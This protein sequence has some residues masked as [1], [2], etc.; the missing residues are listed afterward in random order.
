MRKKFT[1][2]IEEDSIAWLKQ[3]ALKQEIATGSKV[4][5]ADIINELIEK[6]KTM[7]KFEIIENTVEIKDIRDYY[8]G[9][10]YEQTG[11]QDPSIEATYSTKKEAL[12]AL[13]SYK[14]GAR[15]LSGYWL[16]TEYYVAES[17]YQDDEW[18][19]GGDVWEYAPFDW[20]GLYTDRDLDSM[21]TGGEARAIPGRGCDYIIIKDGKDKEVAYAEELVP[22]D[23]D[24][25]KIYDT[26]DERNGKLIEEI[27]RQFETLLK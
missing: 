12:E 26:Q 4:S 27:G 11:D 5:A 15:K 20:S 9:I 14:G 8:E 17:D 23:W 24:E 2:Y 19:A 18:V 1:T 25:D 3:E 7:K 6:E 21:V 16:I 10:T 13:K 22:E